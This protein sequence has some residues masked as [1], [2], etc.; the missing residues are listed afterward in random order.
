MSG[1]ISH[2]SPMSQLVEMMLGALLTLALRGLTTIPRPALWCSGGILFVALQID[3]W[4]APWNS[5]L[6]ASALHGSGILIWACVTDLVCER[7]AALIR[8]IG[9]L[10]HGND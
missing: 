4:I 6:Q 2:L 5:S 7:H 8:F 10:R 3:F 9:S 1:L